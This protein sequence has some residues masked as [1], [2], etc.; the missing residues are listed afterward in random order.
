MLTIP[1]IPATSADK[2]ES[3]HPS[4]EDWFNFVHRADASGI[5]E[6]RFDCEAGIR[7]SLQSG[8]QPAL[9]HFL[10]MQTMLK[11]GYVVL[12][13]CDLH[14]IIAHAKDSQRREAIEA[15]LPPLNLSWEG[16]PPAS[17]QKQAA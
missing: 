3:I 9:A 1:A 7:K 6:R 11:A 4:E 2:F 12:H 13:E 16:R 15:N 10:A 8:D 17:L 14:F 5:C